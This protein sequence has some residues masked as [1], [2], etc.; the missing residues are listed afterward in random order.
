MELLTRIG[1]RGAAI[2][3]ICSAAVSLATLAN[4][5]AASKS[6]PGVRLQRLPEG[7][8]QPRV[9]I[10]ARGV[11]HLTYFSGALAHGDVFYSRI[12]ASGALA[13][14]VKVNSTPRS[15]IAVGSVR[16]PRL[17]VADG[18]VHVVW[19][20]AEHQD[21]G[22]PIFYTRS[23]PDG[24]F[25]PERNLHQ[26]EGP[27]DGGSV[28]AD[29]AGHVFVA[30]H[31]LLPGGKGEDE[32]R[33]WV[34]RSRDE[35][36]TFGRETAASPDVEGACGCCGTEALVD[37]RGD[38]FLLYRGAREITHRNSILL[39]S[40]DHGSSFTSNRLQ[41]WTVATCPMSTFSLAASNDGVVAA[42]E[43]AGQVYWTSVHGT[44]PSTAIAAPGEAGTRRHPSLARNAD[45]ETLLA[46]T[47]GMGFTKAGTLAWQV[48]DRS[49]APLGGI[50]HGGSVPAGSLVAAYATPEAGFA[51]VY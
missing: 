14:P 41:E 31:G 15:A 20:G 16:G 21:E 46:W 27:L 18:R 44:D 1:V 11:V 7:A 35:G 37:R 48:F 19:M 50:G 26:L 9:A 38:L 42:W 40:T 13:S 4:V 43:T 25:E 8:V 6:A 23:R 32:R 29:N 39:A 3:C 49:G 10:D 24:S 12:D 28:A 30:W 5:D 47:E 17:A 36:A 45:G 51:I 22:V 34:A 2:A 33:A